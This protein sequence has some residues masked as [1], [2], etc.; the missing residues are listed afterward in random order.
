[1]I[2]KRTIL[3]FS[4]LSIVVSTLGSETVAQQASST[5][6]QPGICEREG[7]Q[8]V[9]E[10]PVRAGRSV[11]AP[12]RVRDVKPALAETPPK[13]LGRGLW[14]GEYVI[15]LAGKV[16]HVSPTREI[17]F[18][19]P[20]PSFNA[21]IVEAIRQWEF[22]PPVSNGQPTPMCVTATVSVNWQ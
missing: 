19:P 1:V 8:F 15:D 18:T 22:E 10:R 14:V 20:F 4:A 7:Q 5:L 9:G 3:T 12:R 17:E 13:T 11:R 16:A 2:S 6:D 21:A